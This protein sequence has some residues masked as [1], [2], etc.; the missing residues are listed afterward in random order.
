CS[1]TELLEENET[2]LS[3]RELVS[4]PGRIGL[5]SLLQ[6]IAKLRTVRN[7]QLPYD[8]FNGIPPK[9]IRS[10]RQRAVSEDIRELRMHPDS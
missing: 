7:I 10:Y 6:E 1:H 8:L 3:F 5:D 2:I 4:D 9:M